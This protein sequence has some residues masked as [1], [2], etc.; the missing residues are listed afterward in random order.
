MKPPSVAADSL[1]RLFFALWP[2]E[3]VRASLARWAAKIHAGNA[4]RVMQPRNLHMTVVFIG[5]APRSA[6]PR[7][8]AAANTVTMVSL[9]LR[10]DCCRYWKRNRIVWAGCEAPQALQELS[11][12][13]RAAI[14]RAGVSFDHRAFVPHLTLLRD[15][16]LLNGLPESTSLEPIEWIVRDFVLVASD[17]DAEGPLYRIIGGPFG[18]PAA[19]YPPT[20]SGNE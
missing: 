19:A 10:I 1:T 16:R 15:A 14:E 12:S 17:R 6:L 13:L 2:D 11:A 4:G 3:T 9:Q 5:N 18:D 8:V 20:I 7:I